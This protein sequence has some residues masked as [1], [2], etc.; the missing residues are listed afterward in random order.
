M[1]HANS[2]CA[3]CGQDHNSSSCLTVPT[4]DARKQ[5]LRHSGRCFICLRHNHMS[6]TCQSTMRCSHCRGKHHSS[7]C[8]HTTPA[9]STTQNTVSLIIYVSN[10]TQ[11]LLQTAMVYSDRDRPD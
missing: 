8:Q 11:T 1:T 4:A 3:Y 5:S 7:I 9:A 10:N 2:N 6:R